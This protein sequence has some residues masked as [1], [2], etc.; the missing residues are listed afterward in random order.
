[1]EADLLPLL[2]KGDAVHLCEHLDPALD[3]PGFRR[4]VPEPLDELLGLGDLLLLVLGRR[5]EDCPAL[6]LA[7]VKAS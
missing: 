2:G 7:A 5:F 6:R 1:M 3:L 4:L